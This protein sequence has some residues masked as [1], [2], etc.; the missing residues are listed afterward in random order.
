MPWQE[1]PVVSR[2][3]EQTGGWRDDPVVGPQQPQAEPPPKT[4]TEGSLRK[5]LSKYYLPAGAAE[6]A[7]HVG[8][9]MVATPINELIAAGADALPGGRTGADV[10][11]NPPVG[12][13]QPRT[14]IGKNIVGGINTLMT[15]IT[16]AIEWGAD[17]SN[18]DPAVRATGHLIKAGIG[19]LPLVGMGRTRGARATAARPRA[20]PYISEAPEMARARDYVSQKTTLDWNAIPQALKTQLTAIAKDSRTLDNLDPAALERQVLIESLPAPLP[21]TRGQLTRDPVQLRNEGNVSATERGKPIRQIYQ[22]QN[23][24]ILENLQILQGRSRGNAA[25]PEAVGESVQGAARGKLELQRREV[26]RLYREAEQAGDLQGRVSA[27]PV[28]A[29]L[30]NSPDLTHLGWVGTWLDQVRGRL[31]SRAVN[32]KEPGPIPDRNSV[33]LKE[34]EDLR[35]AAVARAMDGGTEGYYAGKVISAIDQATE[36]AGGTAYQSARAAR[37][38]QAMEFEEQGGVARLVENRSRTDRA[39]ALEDTWRRTV[40]GGSIDELRAVKRTLLTGGDG[41]TRTA[42]RQAWRDLRAQTLQE[43][44]NQATRSVTRFEDGS[45]NVTPAALERALK[46][47]GPAKLEELFGPGTVAQLD[48]IMEAT[49][50]VKTEPPTGFKG[51]PTFANAIAFLERTLSKVP[52]LGD[53]VTGAVRAGSQIRDMGRAGREVAVAQETPIGNALRST[54]AAQRAGTR[55]NALRQ[56]RYLPPVANALY[57]E[58]EERNALR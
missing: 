56:L 50:I 17:T 18:P 9:G 26:S 54:Q 35:Q 40:V 10:I 7:L 4:R 15:P 49:R 19:V 13:Y 58:E 31:E 8:T 22:S 20:E 39:T 14:E 47:V 57:P 1:D 23:R 3:Q 30:E 25:S 29:V 6:A 28:R 24:A 32:N 44:Y 16:A 53:T 41:A 12:T 45:P 51:S 33:T 37:R 27:L 34:L 21:A 38:A 42:G 2:Q 52:F 36:G 11:D 48:K 55:R 43:I 46:A 5:F